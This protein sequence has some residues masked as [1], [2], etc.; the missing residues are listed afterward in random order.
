MHFEAFG[1]LIMMMIFVR[2]FYWVYLD[3]SGGLETS[4]EVQTVADQQSQSPQC[5]QGVSPI[6]ISRLAVSVHRL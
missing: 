2:V 5:S 4:T 3:V 6:S 1:G